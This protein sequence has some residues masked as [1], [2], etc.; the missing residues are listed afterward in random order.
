MRRIIENNDSFSIHFDYNPNIINDIKLIPGRSFS[1][2]DKSWIVPKSSKSYINAFAKKHRFSLDGEKQTESNVHI[3]RMPEMPVLMQEIPLKIQ[4][5]PYQRQGIAYGLEHKRFINGDACGLGKTGQAIATIIAANAFPCLVIC[6]A[7]LKTNWEREFEKWGHHKATILSDSIKNTWYN[8]FQMKFCDSFITNYESLKKYFVSEIKEQYDEFG[9][10][11]PL[12]LN[13]VKFKASINNFKSIII[14][15]SHKCKDT[16]T[17]Q[18]KLVKGISV[19]KEYIILLS[20][21]PVVNK[22]N[23]LIS[24]L[25][26][27]DRMNDFGGYKNFVS[28]YCDNDNRYHEL[29][30]LLKSNCY[31]RREKADVLKELPPKMRQIVY[32]DITT[33]REYNDALQDLED[34]LKRYRQATD[35]QI[36]K[37][38][39]GEIMVRIG[40]LKNI[41]ARGKIKDAI[42]YISDVI[43]SGEKL[44]LFTHLKEVQQAVFK[45]FPA[46]V[47][48]F[49]DDDTV[50]RQT[51]VDR[52]Q[53]DP[54]VQLII[55]SIKAAG[56]GITLTASSRV[57][58]LELPWHPADCEQ[59]ED[60]THRIGQLDSVNCIYLL[61]KDT[62]DEH[63]YSII[64]SKRSM[65]NAI[66]G[67]RN[68]VE[69]SVQNGVIN[70]LT[71]NL[72]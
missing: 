53:N 11:K 70:L 48:I 26:I 34:Y 67:A 71:K 39:K 18:A 27:L 44:V 46:A 64:D 45:F 15:E 59:C 24:Q 65:S 10:K 40:V 43:D 68:D 32:C 55:C 28:S 4:P 1:F 56:V 66:T 2:Q 57:A 61:G 37:S 19:G 38:M 20:G 60:R 72:K 13:H 33:H 8:L 30:Y 29:N 16:K 35:E 62:I 63:I 52:F 23:D 49:G 7:T 41:S 12:R 47:T 25:G 17:L 51:N 9:K 42:E 5:F 6:P 31:F 14:D 36:R 21:T 50:T 54:R 58:F 22:P 3:G 69:E